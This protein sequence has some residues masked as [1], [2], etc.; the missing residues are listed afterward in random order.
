M[1]SLFLILQTILKVKSLFIVLSIWIILSALPASSI[2]QSGNDETESTSPDLSNARVLVLHSYHHGFTWTDNISRGIQSVFAEQANEIELIFEFMDTRRIYTDDYFEQ[3]E[4][5]Y[6]LKYAGQKFDVI[7]ASDDQAFNFILEPGQEIFPNAPIV[8]TSVSGFDPSRLHNG[9]QVT[10]LLDAIDIETT[11]DVALQLHPNTKEVAVITDMTRTGQALKSK[12]KEAF[13]NYTGRVQFRFLEHETVDELLPQLATLADDT[14]VFLFIFSRD[15]SGRVFSHEQRLKVIADH[16]PVPIYS[17]WE[18][19]LGHGIVGG[20]LT[21]GEQEGRQA[22][23]MAL[24]ILQGENATDIPLER[25]PSR[26]GFDYKQLARFGIDETSLPGSSLVLNRP[27]SM[28]EEYRLLIWGVIG[29]ITLLLVIVAILIGNIVMRK[30]VEVELAEERNL[31]RILIDNIPDFIYVKDPNS[32]FITGNI[33]LAR[34]MGSHTPADLVSKTD[35]DFYPKEYAAEYYADEQQILSSKKGIIDKVESVVDASNN[36]RWQLTTK[37]PLQNNQGKVIGLV[38]IGRDI[39]AQKL[40]EEERENLITELEAKNAE[41]ERFTYTVSHD[42]KS[43][44]VTISGFLG[45]LEKDIARE[46]SGQI[47]GDIER[48]RDAT[49]T[50]QLLLDNLLELSRI[51]RLTNSPELINLTELAGEAIGLV[52]GQ[53]AAQ[54]VQ[55]DVAP[56]LP[57]VWGNRSRLLEVFQNLIDNAVKFMGD[58][59]EPRVEIGFRQIEAETVYFVR[60]N[61]IGIEPRYHDQVFGLFDR[62]DPSIEGTGIG[63]ALAKRIVDVHGGR[64]WVES[65]GLGS[66]STFCFILP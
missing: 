52:A 13:Q 15:E 63:L 11:L 57:A 28:Y 65:E 21:S 53:V 34:L 64:I 14:I 42:L 22:A 20:M 18:F 61:G 66:G 2:A 17:V 35:F 55:V 44:L 12:A 48:I 59:P 16:T 40:A 23:E 1:N 50:M 58:Q 7:I 9:W 60:D 46:N 43:P 4:E 24:R 47:R 49:K 26:Y 5:L 56:D 10:G 45:L 32:H 27:F 8:F 41:L 54:G 6:R 30:R 3:L 36:S 37:L 38:G 29:V 31:L 39:T 33:A 19:Y 25:S 62:L 51:G